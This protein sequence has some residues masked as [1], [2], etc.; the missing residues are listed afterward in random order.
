MWNECKA[1]NVEF[2]ES[3]DTCLIS[4]VSND[5]CTH[6]TFSSGVSLGGAICEMFNGACTGPTAVEDCPSCMSG[7]KTCPSLDLICNG[8]FCY[9]GTLVTSKHNTELLDCRVNCEKTTDCAWFTH[10]S[11]SNLCNL[12]KADGKEKEDERCTSG[13]KGCPVKEPVCNIPRGCD[14]TYLGEQPAADAQSCL[15]KCKNFANKQCKWFTFHDTDNKCY[16][17]V[18]CPKEYDGDGHYLSGEVRCPTAG[19]Q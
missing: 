10:Y 16:L 6:F 4:C 18:D 5:D 14:G 13:Q 7:E 11:D 17:Y 9:L 8:K 1:I 19:T 3:Y 12:M 2:T 15:D